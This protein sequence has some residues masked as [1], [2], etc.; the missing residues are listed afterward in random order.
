MAPT[1]CCHLYCHS[2]TRCQ[3][4][5]PIL[6]LAHPATLP[7]RNRYCHRESSGNGGTRRVSLAPV[8]HFRLPILLPACAH[9]HSCW[10]GEG[11]RHAGGVHIVLGRRHRVRVG[12]ESRARCI[13]PM[14][15][16][17]N[18]A[19]VVA[20]YRA[21]PQARVSARGASSLLCRCGAVTE[22][23]RCE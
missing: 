4:R 19:P 6:P 16:D 12:E 2:P 9:C 15:C 17:P 23:N 21:A 8:L 11:R 7:L 22:G 3:P 20:A 1:P 5:P 14:P 10:H 18:G 13:I